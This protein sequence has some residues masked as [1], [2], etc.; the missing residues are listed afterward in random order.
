MIYKAAN[1]A[2]SINEV[3]AILEELKKEI[4]YDMINWAIDHYDGDDDTASKIAETILYFPDKLRDHA[5]DF[6]T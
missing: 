3:Y 2:A 6:R 5:L 1:A 4:D